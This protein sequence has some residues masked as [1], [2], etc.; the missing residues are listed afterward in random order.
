[1]NDNDERQRA[2]YLKFQPSGQVELGFKFSGPTRLYLEYDGGSLEFEEID[3]R[4][5]RVIERGRLERP[6]KDYGD[7]REAA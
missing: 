4:T 6:E 7:R 3:A 5:G 2:Q 1:M